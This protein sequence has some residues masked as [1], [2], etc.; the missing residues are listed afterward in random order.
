MFLTNSLFS[1]KSLENGYYTKISRQFI[2]KKTHILKVK[3][4]SIEYLTIIDYKGTC[5]LSFEL[6][7]KPYKK[8]FFY[9]DTIALSTRKLFKVDYQNNA[10][11]LDDTQKWK[12][13]INKKQIRIKDLKN[14]KFKLNKNMNEKIISDY[15]T[16]Y[17]K[18]KW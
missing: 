15:R 10:I 6:L 8:W 18:L 11:I 13:N 1:Q 12:I 16:E 5:I 4:D 2:V 17:E 3:N 7:K 14:M 9:G